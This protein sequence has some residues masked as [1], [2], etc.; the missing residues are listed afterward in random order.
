V[1]YIQAHPTFLTHLV[2]SLRT[3]RS[4]RFDHSDRLVRVPA[5]PAETVNVAEFTSM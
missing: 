5:L 2:F 3:L 1:Q 4:L